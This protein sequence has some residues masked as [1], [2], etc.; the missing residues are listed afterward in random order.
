VQGPFSTASTR[1]GNTVKAWP[2]GSASVRLSHG[3]ILVLFLKVEQQQK[4]YKDNLTCK[5][6]FIF[7]LTRIWCFLRLIFKL[8]NS[9]S[10]YFSYMPVTMI[11][12]Y[13]GTK[14]NHP[15]VCTWAL[16]AATATLILRVNDLPFWGIFWAFWNSSS[17]SL[18]LMYIQPELKNHS[19]E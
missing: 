6:L 5:H 14:R 9:T 1:A 8:L 13:L 15:S 18:L 17:T 12:F 11:T 10:N 2:G 19:R 7:L 4:A 3:Q 16:Q